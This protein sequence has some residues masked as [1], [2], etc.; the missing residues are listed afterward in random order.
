MGLWLD[1][2]QHLILMLS[3][4]IGTLRNTFVPPLLRSTIDWSYSPILLIHSGMVCTEAK[5]KALSSKPPV[6]P[7]SYLICLQ[8]CLFSD[9][10]HWH[11]L[12][13]LIGVCVCLRK[14]GNS[15]TELPHSPLHLVAF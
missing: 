5:S 8:L 4:C 6:A 1:I 9:L 3:T 10:L 7:P 12:P 2:Q 14:T 11:C 15:L 13:F